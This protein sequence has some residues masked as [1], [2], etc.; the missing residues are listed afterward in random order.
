[1]I[2]LRDVNKI[3]GKGDGAVHAL[4]DVNLVIEDA[5]FLLKPSLN[6]I[7]KIGITDNATKKGAP[8][9]V[10]KPSI[11]IYLDILVYV[12]FSK[13]FCVMFHSISYLLIKS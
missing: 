8:I 4:K 1:M 9:A 3:Y 13:Q 10:I 7:I 12:I 2:I 5:K 6:A 11:F